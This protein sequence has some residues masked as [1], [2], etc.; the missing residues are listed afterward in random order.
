MTQK[1][2]ISCKTTRKRYETTQNKSNM[3]KNIHRMNKIKHSE[4][5]E[6]RDGLSKVLFTA[7]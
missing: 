2:N 4:Q 1:T 7:N 3:T 5:T 6:A